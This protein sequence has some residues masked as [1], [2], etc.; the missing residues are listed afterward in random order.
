MPVMRENDTLA[1]IGG[2][3]KEETGVRAYDTIHDLL[4]FRL[5]QKETQICL[6]LRSLEAF[7]CLFILAST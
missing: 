7:H 5:K 1:K 4:E 2:K 6:S 3:K